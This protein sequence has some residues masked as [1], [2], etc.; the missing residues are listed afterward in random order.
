MVVFGPLVSCGS[1]ASLL[2]LFCSNLYKF[3]PPP[4]YFIGGALAANSKLLC[5][6]AQYSGRYAPASLSAPPYSPTTILYFC[7]HVLLVMGE[8]VIIRV[9]FPTRMLDAAL[10]WLRVS[11]FYSI[12]HL[13]WVG[14]ER[15][16]VLLG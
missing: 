3:A 14:G 9:P 6:A 13:C 12:R 1:R 8:T 7:Y 16:C 11:A 2:N 10:W 15:A 5:C 4:L